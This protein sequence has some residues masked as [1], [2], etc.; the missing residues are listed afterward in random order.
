ME[1]QSLGFQTDLM[2]RRLSGSAV[3][4]RGD[5]IVVRTP[6]NPD[7]YWGNFLLIPVPVPGHSEIDR[8]LDVFAAEFPEAGH[9][10]V[11]VDGV[12]GQQGG[13]DIAR[14]P[15][16]EAD[17]AE[18][19]TAATL[20]APVPPPEAVLLRQLGSDEDWAG[21]LELRT[22]MEGEGGSAGHRI[23][24]E[25]R[26]QECRSL[27]AGGHGAFFGAVVDGRVCSMLGIVSDG[28][29]TARYQSVDTHPD[30]RRQGLA[31]S[32]VARAAEFARSELAARRLVIVAE[33]D[34]PAIGLYRR[35]GFRRTE[36]QVQLERPLQAS[37][38]V[39]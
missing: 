16:L 13:T 26:I 18:V 20:T 10:A 29:G 17:V 22:A 39:E 15:G 2:V 3:E 5:H 4:D 1:V 6:A 32:L 8:W 23:Y 37:E 25:R 11:G 21:A 14:I 27:V 9:I 36:L 24:Q 31:G 30:H 7:F 33:S 19:M 12:T 34:G 35:L 28:R 38:P